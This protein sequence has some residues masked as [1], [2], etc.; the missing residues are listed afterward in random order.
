MKIK[1]E[2]LNT[3]IESA[4]EMHPKEFLAFLSVG[5]KKDIIEEFVIV[6]QMIYGK[7]SASFNLAMLP[8]DKSIVGTAHSHPSG[9]Y[10]PSIEDL[11]T[12]GK[13]GRIHIIVAYPYNEETWK[14]YDNMGREITLEVI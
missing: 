13:S 5:K 11:Q 12:F 6:P 14:A 2:C 9:S 1:K 10:L 3:I 7:R 4:K 8:V